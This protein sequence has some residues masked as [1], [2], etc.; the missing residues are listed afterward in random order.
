MRTYPAAPEDFAKNRLGIRGVILALV[1]TALYFAAYTYLGTRMLHLLLAG[2]VV[3]AAIL[4][5]PRPGSWLPVLPV[6]FVLGGP[7]IPTGDFNPAL[8]T[9]I[10]LIFTVYYFMDRVVWNRP[11]FVPSPYLG[12]LLWAFLLQTVSVFISIHVHEQH[13]MNAIRDGS[14]VF[15]FAPLAVMIPVL[16]RSKDD[17]RRLHRAAVAA[18][19]VVSLIGVVQYF[20]IEGFSRA[21]VGIGYVYR[22]RI[23]SVFG[24]PN[25]FAG[26]LELGIPPSIALFFLEKKMK[27]KAVALAAVFLGLMSVLYTFSRGGLLAAFVGSGLTLLYIYRRKIWVPVTMGMAAV[28]LL[29]MSAGTFE[30]QMSFFLD[31]EQSFT[32]PTLLHRY[33]TYKGFLQ[34]VREAPLTGVGYGAREHYWGGSRLY[35]F[36]EVRFVRSTQPILRF[37]GL[38][39]LFLNNAVKGGVIS[40]ASVLIML[41]AIF[42][43]FYRVIRKGEVF[44]IL[45]VA[46]TAGIFSFMVHQLVGNQIRFPTVNSFFWYNTGILLAIAALIGRRELK[47]ASD[48]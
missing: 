46:I 37:G 15:T 23:A 9:I 33:V 16:C 32:Q 36:W 28:G 5:Y 7:T 4:V 27:W 45:A 22:G 48:T 31:P 42:A 13:T 44:G 17:I 6:L 35:S 21:D 11:L 24:N 12:L 29:I 2:L 47:D 19:L 3:I 30:R 38:N 40:L 26:Y 39:S 41:A 10:M 14:S 25:I 1:F 20:G 43:A 34:Q 18:V 8:A